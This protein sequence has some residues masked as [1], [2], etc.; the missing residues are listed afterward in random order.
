MK[1]VHF[2]SQK[3]CIFRLKGDC[4]PQ[5]FNI[6]TIKNPVNFSI[7]NVLK[8]SPKLRLSVL[9]NFVLIKKKSVFE[10]IE[11]ARLGLLE[12][13]LMKPE[14]LLGCSDETSAEVMGTHFGNVMAME[15]LEKVQVRVLFY[16]LWKDGSIL[17]GIHERNKVR[18]VI[19]KEI[20]RLHL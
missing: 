10:W 17:A 14:A 9:I 6:R 7:K 18:F 3:N 19:N 16:V 12:D 2:K 20:G 13:Q 8:I 11:S 15:G 4:E 1:K 5:Y